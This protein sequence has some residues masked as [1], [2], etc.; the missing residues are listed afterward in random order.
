MAA[1]KSA[2][3]KDERP[4]RPEF[5]TAQDVAHFCEVDLKTI[6]HWVERGKIAH[7]RTEGRHLRFRRMDVVRF[8]R[9]LD[10]PLPRELVNVRCFVGWAMPRD[11]QPEVH[12]S[13][14]R[15]FAIRDDESAVV[16]LS[17]AFAEPTDAVVLSVE[18]PTFAG[19]SAISAL[20]RDPRT[21][22]MMLAAIAPAAA[23]DELLSAGAD[24][25]IATEDVQTL[26]SRLV[27]ALAVEDVTD[28]RGTP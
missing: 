10:Y 24:L 19:I 1:R 27:R 14:A 28:L 4:A 9:G 16:G 11:A 13:L 25:A 22:W 7:R 21:A 5:Y 23:V 2:A 12:A 18:D 6:H 3:L 15:T 26:P 17:C 8:L 20:K